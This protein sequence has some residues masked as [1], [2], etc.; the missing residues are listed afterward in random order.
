MR[1]VLYCLSALF[2]L[3]CA[4]TSTRPTGGSEPEVRDVPYQ[5][6]DGKDG[7]LRRR[8]MVLPFVDQTA[9]RS[10]KA[11]AAAREALVRAL[12]RTDDYVVIANSDFPKDLKQYLK[13]GEYDLEGLARIGGGMG[14]VAIVEGRIMEIKARRMGDEVGLVRQ[15]RAKVDGAVQLRVVSTKNGHI[16]LN[17]MNSATVED[18][19]TRVAE[20]S[21]SDSTLQDD[22]RL[23]ESV[24]RKAFESLVPRIAQAL[25]K[26]GWEGRIALV[27]GER[28]FLNAGRLSGLQV[29][30]ILKVTDDAEDVYDPETGSLIGKVPGRLKGT[31]EVISYFGRDGSICVVHSG[32]GFHENDIVEVY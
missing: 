25:D 8:V 10:E 14:L 19:T 24:V 9:A 4:I 16:I 26:L 2:F 7:N 20:R 15:S 21:F 13:N 11:S 31:I 32:S 5:A 6:R 1:H 29:G 23:V 30:D 12:R 22:P 17:E 3:G 18:S 28:I 27:K